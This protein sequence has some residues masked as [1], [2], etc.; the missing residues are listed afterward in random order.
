MR[1]TTMKKLN[2]LYKILY[3]RLIDVVWKFYPQ[4]KQP[5]ANN[6]EKYSIGIVTYINRY[7]MFFKTLVKNLCKLFPDVEITIAINGYYDF[8]KQKKYL[9]AVGKQLKKYPNVKKITYNEGQSLSKLWNQLL[10]NSSNQKIFI[11][12]DDIKITPSFRK[13]I[14]GSGVL[15]EEVALLNKSWSHFLI[16]KKTVA[17]TGWFDE[18]FPSVGNEDQDYECRLATEGFK[19]KSFEI[20][21]LKNLI[22]F[23]KDFSYGKKTEVVNKK[24]VSA[25]KDHFNKKWILSDEPKE[26]FHFVRILGKHAKMN[27]GMETPNF[28]PEINYS[29]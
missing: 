25:N 10:I 4:Q 20:P 1:G 13:D 12:N 23:T 15:K 9:E 22:Y 17:Q 3:W 2:T 21:S 16:S 28:Y 14:E 6:S 8:E 26:D 19:I 18:R 27:T 24:Y 7:D 5:S 11:F 29:K